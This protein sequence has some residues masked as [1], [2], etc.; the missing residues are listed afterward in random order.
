MDADTQHTTH[1]TYE[2]GCETER[3]RERDRDRNRRRSRVKGSSCIA[4]PPPVSPPDISCCCQ[5]VGMHVP[6]S[7]RC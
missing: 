7:P 3:I 4:R 1:D 5:L 2:E 6:C